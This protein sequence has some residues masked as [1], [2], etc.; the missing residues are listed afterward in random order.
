M[1]DWLKAVLANAPAI[2]EALKGLFPGGK[3]K[4]KRGRTKPQKEE[5]EE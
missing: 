1:S 4:K 5:V 2:I 3:K